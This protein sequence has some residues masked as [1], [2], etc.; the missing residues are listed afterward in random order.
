MATQ[1]RPATRWVVRPSFEVPATFRNTHDDGAQHGAVPCVQGPVQ[2]L[3]AADLAKGHVRLA[4]RHF[5]MLRASGVPVPAAVSEECT[6]LLNACPA[7]LLQR[8]VLDVERWLQ[9]VTQH[10]CANSLGLRRASARGLVG[11]GTYRS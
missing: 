3:L 9:V 2:A 6:A 11:D 5:L 4:I 1:A 7:R 10:S 8:I